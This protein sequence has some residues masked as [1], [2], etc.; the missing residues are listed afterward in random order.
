MDQ[1]TLKLQERPEDV[2]TGDLPRN[3]M[4]LIDRHLVGQIA[5][6]TRVT[7][8]GIYSIYAAKEGNSK[9][10]SSSPPTLSHQLSPSERAPSLLPRPPN[11]FLG[12]CRAGQD[13]SS[14]PPDLLLSPSLTP[15]PFPLL[16]AS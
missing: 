15:F 13:T 11:A 2:P 7:A 4:V 16:T 3:M 10:Q 1:Q 8:V 9:V 14:R 5:P 6:G 12:Q